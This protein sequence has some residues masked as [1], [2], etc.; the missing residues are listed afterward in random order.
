MTKFDAFDAQVRRAFDL[1]APTYEEEATRKLAGRGY[2]YAELGAAIAKLVPDSGVR[3][4]VLEVGVGTGLLGEQVLKFATSVEL[5]GIDISPAMLAIAES[6]DVY[7]RLDLATA[8]TFAYGR[9]YSLIYSAFVFHSIGNQP[10]FLAG[11]C[12]CLS[13]GAKLVLVDLLPS[14]LENSDQ[15]MRHSRTFEMGSPSNYMEVAS[16]RELVQRY[17]FT[18]LH[19]E[20]LGEERDYNHFWHTL[21]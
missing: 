4:T 18:V 6:R 13:P 16:F 3:G 14:A 1:W 12:S 11:I 17:G 10:R 5:H 20:R 8:D 19:S 9:E 2:S 7:A 21:V 15:G